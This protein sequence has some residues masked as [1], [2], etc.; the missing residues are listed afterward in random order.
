RNVT[1]V[2]TC[3]LPISEPARSVAQKRHAGYMARGFRAAFLWAVFGPGR[4]AQGEKIGPDGVKGRPTARPGGEQKQEA[5]DEIEDAAE[6][7]HTFTSMRGTKQGDKTQAAAPCGGFYFLFS[8]RR[9]WR[10]AKSC[11]ALPRSSMAAHTAAA[12]AMRM[13]ISMEKPPF[14]EKLSPG[15]G[16]ARRPPH[17]RRPR[18]GCPPRGTWGSWRC[19]RSGRWSRGPGRPPRCPG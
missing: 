13:T 4:D 5:C 17:W 7:F 8:L 19:S 15:P 1:G 16:A 12:A 3:A 14:A 6:V 9:V 2:Q 11:Q 18:S 10:S